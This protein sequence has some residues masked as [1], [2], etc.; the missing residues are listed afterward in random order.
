MA[1]FPAMRSLTRKTLTLTVAIAA[2]IFAASTAQARSFRVVQIPN[3]AVNG[4]LTCH[5]FA[6]GPRNPFGQEIEDHHLDSIA[7]NVV[8]SAALA[9]LDSD[10]DGASNGKELQ[11]PAGAWRVRQPNPGSEALVTHPGVPDAP[12]SVPALS[13]AAAL[14]LCALL[15]WA[16][17]KTF[18]A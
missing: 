5:I 6:G 15:C 10:K 18:R 16:S 13:G 17:R 14:M 7:G 4:C 9:A 3:G 8:W 12:K 1:Y 11:D 2:A